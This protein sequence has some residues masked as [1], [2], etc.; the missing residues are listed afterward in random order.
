MPSARIWMP[1][2]RATTSHASAAGQP[3]SGYSVVLPSTIERLAEPA[4]DPAAS[5]VAAQASAAARE[6]R[7]T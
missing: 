2:T 5:A 6:Q 3:D 7:K 1:V 4:G